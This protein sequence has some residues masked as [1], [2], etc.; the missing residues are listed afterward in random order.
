MQADQFTNCIGESREH[1]FLADRDLSSSGDDDYDADEDAD[2]DDAEDG[3]DRATARV[4]GGLRELLGLACDVE[5][6]PMHKVR[7]SAQLPPVPAPP[8][9]AR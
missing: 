2:M 5:R 3:A 8:K 6:E 1:R 7:K 4:S 9:H